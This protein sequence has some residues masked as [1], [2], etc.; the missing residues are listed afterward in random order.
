MRCSCDNRKLAYRILHQLVHYAFASVY[1]FTVAL[2]RLLYFFVLLLQ[3]FPLVPRFVA[4]KI[5]LS[6]VR[7]KSTKL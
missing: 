7:R 3:S 5:Y 6:L 4:H 1:F 2:D